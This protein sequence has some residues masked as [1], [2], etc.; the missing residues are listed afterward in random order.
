MSWLTSVLGT[1]HDEKSVAPWWVK[2]SDNHDYLMAM[3]NRQ[4]EYFFLTTLGKQNQTRLVIKRYSGAGASWALYLPSGKLLIINLMNHGAL[5]IRL[6]V[7]RDHEH[8]AMKSSLKLLDN[9][10]SSFD[11]QAVYRRFKKTFWQ[12]LELDKASRPDADD[13][14][15][16]ENDKK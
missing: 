1:K 3:V 8:Y 7:R 12:Y 16:N 2:T 10:E 11:R 5:A 9:V 6:E 14:D 15:T 4:L 13:V